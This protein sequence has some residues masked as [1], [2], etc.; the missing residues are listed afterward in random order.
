MKKISILA[1]AAIAL[2]SCGNTYEAKAPVLTNT[3]DSVNYALGLLNGAQIKMM[4]LADADEAA[5]QTAA[6]ELGDALTRGWEGKVEELS[7]VEN[8]ARSIASGIKDSEKKGL[9]NNPLWALNEKVLFQGLVNAIYGEEDV[10][11]QEEARTFFQQ[12]WQSI[13]RN[14]EAEPLKAIKG[15][16]PSKAKKIEL[17]SL[18]DSLNYAFGLLNGGDVA[19]YLTNDSTG[20]EKENFIKAVNKALKSSVKYPQLVMMGENVGK[21]IFTQA[22]GGLVGEPSLTTDFELIRQGFVNGVLGFEG[23]DVQDAQRWVQ[24]TMDKIKYGDSKAEGEAF[25]AANKLKEGIITTESGLQYEVLKEGKGKKPAATDRVKVHYHGTLINGTV[26][27]S[28]VERGEPI[29]FAL[30]QVIAGWTE[31][32]QLMSVG[33]KYRFYIPQELAYGSR[34]AGSIPPYSALIFE[35]ELLGIEK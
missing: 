20:K 1:L 32:V 9:V 15:S 21:T 33:S 34:N 17:K 14:V 22:E 29:T 7:Q 11:T 35:V 27:D 2:I 4:Q 13:D 6:N 8:V 31:G 23:W 19:Y 30:N 24:E 10:M 16:C 28:S 18:N 26:F 25:L 5:L 12:Q 3:N